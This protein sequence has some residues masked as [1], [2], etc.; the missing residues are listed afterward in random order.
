[1]QAA[2]DPR[3]DDCNPQRPSSRSANSTTRLL[4]AE[5]SAG[6]SQLESCSTMIQPA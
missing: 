1:V 5:A 6:G 4:I 3:A 2:H